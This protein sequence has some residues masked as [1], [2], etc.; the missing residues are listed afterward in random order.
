VSASTA[1]D[2]IDCA[3]IAWAAD[4][5]DLPPLEFKALS[6]LSRKAGAAGAVR[7]SQADLAADMKMTVRSVVTALAGLEARGLIDRR[8]GHGAGRGKGRQA[9]FIV[10]ALHRAKFASCNDFTEEVAQCISC[11]VKE[12]PT[13]SAERGPTSPAPRVRGLTNLSKGLSPSEANASSG[14]AI[15]EK[16]SKPKSD[17]GHSLPP[18]WKLEPWMVAYC[19][20]HKYTAHE[21]AFIAMR[22][23]TFWR[24]QSGA[25]GRKADWARTFQTWVMNEKR[26][27][28]QQGA[29]AWSAPETVG[30]GV[31]IIDH[32]AERARQQA[33]YAA[34]KAA[35]PGELFQ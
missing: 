28:V 11:E 22:F 9:D 8:K 4:Q 29:A 26:W 20:K 1:A 5:C 13:K 15:S 12:N 19:A 21:A 18:D 16:G 30:S 35:R 17:R 32:E 14:V 34:R 31:E 7:L 2:L 25:R 33:A 23:E 6:R 24:A 10:L 27:Q 3:T